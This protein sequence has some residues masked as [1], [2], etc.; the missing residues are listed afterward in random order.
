VPPVQG[1]IHV[2]AQGATQLAALVSGVTPPEVQAQASI[3]FWEQEPYAI[4]HEVPE[5]DAIPH[6]ALARDETQREARGPRAILSAIFP[7]AHCA[8]ASASRP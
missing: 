2:A 7:S 6:E 4:P 1:E 5:Q 8:M 3:H